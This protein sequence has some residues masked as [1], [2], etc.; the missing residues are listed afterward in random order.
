MGFPKPIC[1][2]NKGRHVKE[3]PVSKGLASR[4]GLQPKLGGEKFI[5]PV[6]RQKCPIEQKHEIQGD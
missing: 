4:F 2:L 3:Q 6:S 1:L 5:D